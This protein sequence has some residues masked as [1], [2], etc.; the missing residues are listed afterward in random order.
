MEI[1]YE[2]RVAKATGAVSVAVELTY[3][4]PQSRDA[5]KEARNCVLFAKN[6][7]GAYYAQ[8]YLK[9]Q[10]INMILSRIATIKLSLCHSLVQL[11]MLF[12]IV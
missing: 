9:F 5:I 6:A 4:M 7:L 10:F 1:E 12:S 3:D 11:V 2:L 8:L